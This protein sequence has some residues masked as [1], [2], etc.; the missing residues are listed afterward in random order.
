MLIILLQALKFQKVF[1]SGVLPM[2]QVPRRVVVPHAL[3]VIPSDYM[4]T[5]VVNSNLCSGGLVAGDTIAFKPDIGLDLSGSDGIGVRIRNPGPANFTVEVWHG[6][7][8]GLW[9]LAPGGGAASTKPVVMNE[10]FNSGA[11]SLSVR[12]YA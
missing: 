4:F 7:A 5:M 2:T 11:I 12:A 1:D 10:L 9:C 3:G 8:P 6:S